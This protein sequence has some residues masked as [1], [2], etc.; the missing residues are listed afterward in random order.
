MKPAEF[1]RDYCGLDLREFQEDWL[2]ELF[3][4]K[5]GERV[6][7]QALWGVPRGNG[8]TEIA[9]AVALYMLVAD[10]RRAEVYIAAGSRDQAT[11]AF[12][13]ARR[14]VE[15]GPLA[16][17]QGPAR[18]PAD[19]GAATRTRTLHVIS[20]DGSAPARPAADLRDLRR[21]PGAEEA[22]PV[23]GSGRR[24]VQ[25]PRRRFWSASRPRDMTRTRYSPR[26]ASAARRA[27]TRGFFTAGTRRRESLPYD[28]PETWKIA[29]PALAANARSC[30]SRGS[31]TTCGGC[32]K[33]VSP[34]APE[35]VDGIRG[36]LDHR[37]R[38][39]RL[40]RRAE[41]KPRLR[42]RARGRRLDPPRRHRVVT[43]QR[44][45]RRRLSRRASDLGAQ[46]RSG[47]AAGGGREPH[48][49]PGRALRALR[50]AVRPAVLQPL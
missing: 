34:L 15:D 23:R 9:A 6:H 12:K 36:D 48:P 11:L 7:T 32:T 42:D 14:M 20:A 38:L 37:R 46:T 44:D 8:K 4:T 39:G 31:R 33:R 40:R 1:I 30:G 45:P 47:R 50:G 41:L 16:E 26:N 18:L 25:A 29:N 43:V 3:E 24:A 17:G 10:V 21:A 13:A 2:A 49:H 5:N 27:R 28:D 19:G 35:P 22:R